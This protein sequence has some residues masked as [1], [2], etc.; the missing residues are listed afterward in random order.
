MRLSKEFRVNNVYTKET[1][2]QVVFRVLSGELLKSEGRREYGIPGSVALDGW[3][4][5]RMLF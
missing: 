3:R 4:S 1:K 2:K 5:T